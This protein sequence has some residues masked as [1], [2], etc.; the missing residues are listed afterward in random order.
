MQLG[1]HQA[2][3]LRGLAE[4]PGVAMLADNP[5]LPASAE[6][7]HAAYRRVVDGVFAIGFSAAGGYGLLLAGLLAASWRR[8]PL[9]IRKML[10]PM[11]ASALCYALPLMVIAPAAE[12]RYLL[13]SMLACW[14]AAIILLTRLRT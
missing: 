12:S 3:A 5:V 6:S 7:W 4:A 13:W 2:P 8:Q 1:A 11:L 9:L 14:G 10:A